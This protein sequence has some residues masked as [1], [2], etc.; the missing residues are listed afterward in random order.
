[1]PPS[2]N[3]DGGMSIHFVALVEVTGDIGKTLEGESEEERPSAAPVFWLLILMKSR[4]AV[5]VKATSS[6]DPAKTAGAPVKVAERAG[7]PSRRYMAVGLPL[8]LA[9]AILV[10]GLRVVCKDKKTLKMFSV[11]S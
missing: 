7:N 9:A 10:S 8:G 1:M 4:Q 2:T 5:T 3:A 11:S 6:L